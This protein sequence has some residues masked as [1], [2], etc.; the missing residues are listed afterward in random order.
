MGQNYLA[1]DVLISKLHVC[2]YPNFHVLLVACGKA[3]MWHQWGVV[4]ERGW[5]E[6]GC[7]DWWIMT[8]WA[9]TFQSSSYGPTW[10][11]HLS[12]SIGWLFLSYNRRAASPVIVFEPVASGMGDISSKHYDWCLTTNPQGLPLSISFAGSG[13]TASIG[14]LFCIELMLPCHTSWFRS[15]E[16]CCWDGCKVS[17]S[18]KLLTRTQTSWRKVV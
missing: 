15:T 3:S 17:K 4:C 14:M 5:K 8:L 16:G 2:I 9:S 18:A 13:K 12:K 11:A 7:Y 10:P 1:Y 6:I